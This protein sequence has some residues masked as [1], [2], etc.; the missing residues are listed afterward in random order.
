[1]LNQ[2][3][4][5]VTRSTTFSQASEAG[6]QHCDDAV[7]QMTFLFGQD[8]VPANPFR[9]QGLKRAMKMNGTCGRS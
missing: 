1:M 6:A 2:A 8:H 3:T 4:C 5:T 9:W 7:G